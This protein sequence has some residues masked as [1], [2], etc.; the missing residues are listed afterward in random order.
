MAAG[1]LC[2]LSPQPA[3]VWQ[4]RAVRL[5]YEHALTAHVGL[6]RAQP[7][8]RNGV[9]WVLA[10]LLPRHQSAAASPGAALRSY[11]FAMLHAQAL[12]LAAEFSVALGV[13]VVTASKVLLLLPL[14]FGGGGGGRTFF[15]PSLALGS[16]MIC[17]RCR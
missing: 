6:A 5:V 17:N 3:P 2:S 15:A 12:A 16:G 14:R 9:A 8:L 13:H 1:A 4:V 11:T 7:F 10:V